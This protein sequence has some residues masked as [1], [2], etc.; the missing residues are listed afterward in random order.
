MFLK[1]CFKYQQVFPIYHYGNLVL[2]SNSLKLKKKKQKFQLM[3]YINFVND[4]ILTSLFKKHT[5][6]V[7]N[8]QIKKFRHGEVK[9]LAQSHT[10]NWYRT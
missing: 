1:F 8:I 6:S 9:T 5:Y 4:F 7:Y 3:I 2:R 10:T